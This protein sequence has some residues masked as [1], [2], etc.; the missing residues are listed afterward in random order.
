MHKKEMAGEANINKRRIDEIAT[1]L[2]EWGNVAPAETL[3]VRL[4]PPL[5]RSPP[6]RCQRADANDG[7]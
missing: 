5:I 6:P 3:Q 4:P 1:F 7:H 2:N